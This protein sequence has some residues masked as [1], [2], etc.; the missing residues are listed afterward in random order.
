MSK[1]KKF[2]NVNMEIN[3][4]NNNNNSI[5]NN[6]SNQNNIDKSK[7]INKITNIYHMEPKEIKEKEK[8]ENANRYGLRKVIE[9]GKGNVNIRGGALVRPDMYKVIQ[10]EEMYL[11]INPHTTDGRYL[12]DHIHINAESVDK[13]IKQF[14]TY[15][16]L[17]YIGF[18]GR[19]YNY[20]ENRLD[21]LSVDTTENNGLIVI[22]GQTIY[23][24]TSRLYDIIGDYYPILNWLK[25]DIYNDE[26]VSIIEFLNDKINYMVGSDII[27]NFIYDYIV[28]SYFLECSHKS[29]YLDSLNL[30]KQNPNV[31]I[32]LII[33][34]ASAIYKLQSMNQIGIDELFKYIGYD[35]TS[36]Q[37]I[38]GFESYKENN[39]FKEFEQMIGKE[40]SWQMIIYRRQN[41][42]LNRF[43]IPNKENVIK[44]GLSVINDMK[45]DILQMLDSR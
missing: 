30:N 35:I 18:I 38:K 24:T 28:Y 20:N 11:I 7:E 9:E 27:K 3:G 41:L 42:D 22:P 40:K 15:K 33:I 25:Y 1:K 43:E 8:I 32:D 6:K 45:D 37:G 14:Q 34:L 16:K 29:L 13:A 19:P 36:M 44:I 17:L 26:Y 39:N 23:V 5:K 21:G 2:K 4:D 10:N 12:S 31:L